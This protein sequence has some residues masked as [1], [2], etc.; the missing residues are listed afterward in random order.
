MVVATIA[1]TIATIMLDELVSP[2]V[3]V[4]S[5]FGA[6]SPIIFSAVIESVLTAGLGEGTE[7]ISTGRDVAIGGFVGASVGASVGLL[8]G[9]GQNRTG[10][11][12]GGAAVTV[13][14]GLCV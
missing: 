14:V 5:V 7:T 3:A 12:V 2:E 13:G 6:T 4:L 10:A 1:L 11:R 9:K 8:V